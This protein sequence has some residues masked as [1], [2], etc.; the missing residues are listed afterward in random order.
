MNQTLLDDVLSSLGTDLHNPKLLWQIGI[1]LIC[2]GLG[3]AGARMLRKL[4]TGSDRELRFVRLGVESFGRVLSPVLALMLIAVARPILGQWQQVNVLRLAIP[5]VASFALIRFAFYVLRRVFARGGHAGSLL[6]MFE[7]V[8]AVVVWVGVA[9]YITGLWPELIGYLDNTLVPVGRHKESLL[10]IVQGAVSVVVTV[11]LAL[12]CSALLEERLMRLDTMHSSMRVVMARLGKALL[13]LVAVLVSLSLVGIDLTVLSVF[14]GAL[15]VGLGL[16]LQK[17]VSSYISGFVI[18]LERSLAIGDMVTVDK[19]YGQVTRINTRYTI[20]RSLDGVE[21][22]IPNEMLIAS[23]VQNHSLSDR[24]L[25]LNTQ[26]T[27]AYETDIEPLIAQLGAV[28][29]QVDRV[30]KEPA[31]QAQLIRFG[32]DGLEMEIGFWI[33]DPENGRMNVVSE[34]NRAIWKLVQDRKI[35]LPYPQREI[36]IMGGW[37]NEGNLIPVVTPVTPPVSSP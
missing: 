19:Y 24:V 17:I 29:M 1:L 11:I 20:V 10:S 30:L 15:G 28:A 13:V 9:L 32:Q 31:P 3:W 35:R 12:W 8:F 7:K 33:S 2:F 37:S 23:P 4:V 34:V 14:G 16:G 26:L 5:L 36:H 18:L 21:T 22:V 25:R 6:L 27:V